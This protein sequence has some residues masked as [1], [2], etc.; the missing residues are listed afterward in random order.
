MFHRA[1]RTAP[2]QTLKRRQIIFVPIGM[3][4][5]LKA[6]QRHASEVGDLFF[7]DQLHRGHDIPLG[8]HYNFATN[9]KA[10][11]HHRDFARDVE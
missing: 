4:H 9:R 10:D 11:E 2:G 5:Q 6:H 7:L 8:H 1:R 3:R